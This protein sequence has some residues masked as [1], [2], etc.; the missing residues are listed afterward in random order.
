LRQ[1]GIGG[2]ERTA[3]SPTLLQRAAVLGINRSHLAG[4]ERQLAA[5]VGIQPPLE[6]AW[7]AL[8]SNKRN[9]N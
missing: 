1:F 9:H 7:T 8:E 6:A 4:A 3:K 2:I 5:D